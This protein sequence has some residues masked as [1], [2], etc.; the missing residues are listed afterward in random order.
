MTNKELEVAIESARR[1]LA[2]LGE[3]AA[4]TGVSI[5]E[6]AK[7]LRN[8]VNPVNPITFAGTKPINANVITKTKIYE[9]LTQEKEE[10]IE[11]MIDKEYT[12]VYSDAEFDFNTKFEFE[13][14]M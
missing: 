7:S 5:E 10:K 14:M 9:E 3:T 12:S 13:N 6:A 1:T 4:Q 8:W 2:K 11:P